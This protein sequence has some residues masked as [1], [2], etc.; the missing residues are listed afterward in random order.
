MNIYDKAHEF[1]KELGKCDEIV[2]LREASKKIEGNENN[3][4]M[5]DDFRRLQIQAYTE[6]MQNGSISQE[7]QEKL[8]NMG[9]IISTNPLVTEYLQ[10]EQRFSIMW[11]DVLKILN[12]G[13]GIDF[14]FGMSK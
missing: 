10:V 6:Q 11:D 13:I 4:K 14:A 8:K 12:D 2:S 5:L 9:P 3:K 7:T 1:A